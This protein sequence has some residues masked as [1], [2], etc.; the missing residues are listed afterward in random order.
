MLLYSH[1]QFITSPWR[2]EADAEGIGRGVN[3]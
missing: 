3:P 1:L 2:G